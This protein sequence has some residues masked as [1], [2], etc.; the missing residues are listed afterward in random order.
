M[1]PTR[2]VWGVLTTPDDDWYDAR[3]QAAIDR[4]DAERDCRD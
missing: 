4:A 2:L 1:T 3:E